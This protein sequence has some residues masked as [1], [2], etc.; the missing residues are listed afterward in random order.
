MAIL[1]I[2]KVYMKTTPTNENSIHITVDESKPGSGKTFNAINRM[3]SFPGRY[4]FVTERKESIHS[5]ANDCKKF[6]HLRGRHLLVWPLD[7]DNL[8]P[9]HTSVREAVEN[10][11]QRF[12]NQV[13]VV[14]VISHSAFMMCDLGDFRG[15]HAIIDEIPSVLTIQE[16][17]TF[18]DE[19]FFRDHYTLQKLDGYEGWSVVGQTPKGKRLTSRHL[20][21]DDS[22]R[23]LRSFHQRVIESSVVCNLTEWSEMGTACETDHGKLAPVWIWGSLFTLS[24]LKA[25]ETITILGYRFRD[26]LSCKLLV[27]AAARDGLGTSWNV[28][29][30][31]RPVPWQSRSVRIVYF[32][33]RTASKYH[34]T[35]ASGREHLSRIDAY[36]AVHMSPQSIW[37][38]RS[39]YMGSFK[40]LPTTNC[41]KPRQAGSNEFASCNEAAIIYSAKASPN[42][43]GLLST[44]G[45]DEAAWTS[46]NEFETILQFVTRTS[47]RD[48]HSTAPVTLYVYDKAQA[49]YVAERLGVLSHIDLTVEPVDL[50]VDTAQR[51][52]G[53]KV[54]I[55]SEKEIAERKD[56]KRAQNAEWARKNRLASKGGSNDKV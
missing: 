10:V 15:W 14:A 54:K 32:S 53:P 22:H 38:T 16:V 9:T 31:S 26:S 36:L 13:H 51:A 39:A 5:V 1:P 29:A 44:H 3:S 6:A 33:G 46:T 34:L 17:Q 27:S 4:L 21:Q 19:A 48:P 40:K 8:P 7:A 18:K 42:V 2:S 56:R 45:V 11:P 41:Q 35:S 55:L 47:L 43:R 20:Y 23:H 52:R 12:R 24:A 49:G 28:I 50:G 30:S 25:F 37:S